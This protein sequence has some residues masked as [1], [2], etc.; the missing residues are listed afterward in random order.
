MIPCFPKFIK[1]MSRDRNFDI[2]Y[3]CAVTLMTMGVITDEQFK[4]FVVMY[5]ANYGVG[6]SMQDDAHYDI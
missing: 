6:T 5:I 4:K 1:T 3:V 2:Q